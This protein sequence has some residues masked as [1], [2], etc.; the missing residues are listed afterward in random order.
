MDLLPWR[1]LL[2]RQ[3]FQLAQHSSDTLTNS[4]PG[5]KWCQN[6]LCPPS[7][8]KPAAGCL[9]SLSSLDWVS[10]IVPHHVSTMLTFAFPGTAGSTPALPHHLFVVTTPFLDHLSRTEAP[11]V[12]MSHPTEVAAGGGIGLTL[13]AVG[14][15]LRKT[16]AVETIH[17]L[18][19]ALGGMELTSQAR[20]ILA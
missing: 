4:I 9:H 2:V 8:E 18:V 1:A 5:Y 14:M 19:T 17:L 15:G 10:T 7:Y 11:V 3:P 20:V 6:R 12:A 13:P 16:T